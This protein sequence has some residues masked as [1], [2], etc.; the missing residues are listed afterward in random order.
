MAD[1]FTTYLNLDQPEVG[2]SN[3]TW[4]TKLNADLA[5]IDALFSFTGTGTV[6]VRDMNGNAQATGINIQNAAGTSRFLEI[7]TGTPNTA[8]PGLLRWSFGGGSATESGGNAGTP[9]NL[10]RYDDTGAF[11]NVSLQINRATGLATFETTPNVGAFPVWHQGNDGLLIPL[12][13]IVPYLGSAAPTNWLFCYGQPISR[14][15]YAALFAVIGSAYGAGD[16]STTFNLPDLRN[17]AIVGLGNMGGTP[18]GLI[19][20]SGNNVQGSTMGA[21]SAMLTQANLP[22][23]SPTF[24]GT[25]PGG[26]FAQ[27]NGAFGTDDS[28]GGVAFNPVRA[29]DLSNAAM[30][31]PSGT[32]SPLGSDTPF[33]IVQPSFVLPYIVRALA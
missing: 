13:S 3:D 19:T 26:S 30:P 21:E 11:L 2:S 4:G 27:W 12:G 20:L 9:L 31:T 17:M 25:S 7:T 28:G 1:T 16:G 6:V 29:T 10:E 15:T 24:T 14:A 5:I 8:S 32:I 18:R 33:E 23:V 22:A